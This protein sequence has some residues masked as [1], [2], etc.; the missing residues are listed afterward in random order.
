MSSAS[1]Y[2]P[3][4]RPFD[5]AHRREDCCKPDGF[6]PA[7]FVTLEDVDLWWF[8]ILARAWI[9]LDLANTLREH[10]IQFRRRDNARPI[11]R[12]DRVG[13]ASVLE[14][15]AKASMGYLKVSDVSSYSF[16]ENDISLTLR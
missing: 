6:T 14:S 16:E 1:V 13:K 12:L 7:M 2:R 9:D 5:E 8:D 3:H 10:V 11:P 15:I 4:V